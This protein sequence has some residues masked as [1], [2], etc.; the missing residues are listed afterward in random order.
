[1]APVIRGLVTAVSR[2]DHQMCCARAD[3]V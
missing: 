1:M 3:L 2:P